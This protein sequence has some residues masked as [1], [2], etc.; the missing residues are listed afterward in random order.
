[1]KDIPHFFYSGICLGMFDPIGKDEQGVLIRPRQ[2]DRDA[3]AA[4]VSLGRL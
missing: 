2:A 4:S 1:M 3:R